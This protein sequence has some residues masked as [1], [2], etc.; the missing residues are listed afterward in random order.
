M[1]ELSTLLFVHIP[2][3]AGTSFR[4]AARRALGE[5]I[6][7]DYGP[8]SRNTSPL[9]REHLYPEGKYPD[10]EHAAA[11]EAYRKMLVE[12]RIVM[13]GGHL[14]YERY[15]QLFPPNQVITMLREPVARVLS[16][17]HHEVR[18][19]S[20]GGSVLE[21]CE[22][23]KHRNLQWRLLRGVPLKRLNFGLTE[24]YADSL[25]LLQQRLGVPLVQLHEN[26]SKE[27]SRAI[28]TLAPDI[29]ETIRGWNEKDVTLY[30]RAVALF[31]LRIT[32]L[33]RV[34]RTAARAG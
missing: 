22:L 34:R 2:K 29:V 28:D 26:R 13:A 33:R 20:F 14:R 23:R 12:H 10:G 31:D 27:A 16:H 9:V 5:R 25:E 21:F 6:A 30:E 4:M 18:K 7:F 11:F 8:N 17:Y 15:A 32:R 24:R 19:G 3:T 1:E